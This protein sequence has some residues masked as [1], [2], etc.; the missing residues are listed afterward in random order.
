MNA[1][2]DCHKTTP[3]IFFK[4]TVDRNIYAITIAIGGH[5]RSGMVFSES[6]F[7]QCCQFRPN[8]RQIS[9]FSVLTRGPGTRDPGTHTLYDCSTRSRYM[10]YMLFGR[11]CARGRGAL[12]C[13]CGHYGKHAWCKL[14]EKRRDIE[15]DGKRDNLHSSKIDRHEETCY[16]LR[17]INSGL[18]L[19]RPNI[20]H[21]ALGPDRAPHQRGPPTIEYLEPVCKFQVL[22]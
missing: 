14:T 17:A 1:E 20:R 10:K 15:R 21:L 6:R 18:A 16:V 3:P 5:A 19:L 4:V 8:L 2:P 11:C 13:G 12:P 7:I 22:R 9:H